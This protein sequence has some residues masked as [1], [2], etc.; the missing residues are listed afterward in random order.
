MTSKELEDLFEKN[1]ESDWVIDE[2]IGLSQN[3]LNRDRIALR[4]KYCGNRKEH[5]LGNIKYSLLKNYSHCRCQSCSR[6]QKRENSSI[7]LLMK[8]ESTLDGIVHLSWKLDRS[9]IHKNILYNAKTPL[10]LMCTECHT[11]KYHSWSNIKT[12]RINQD[13]IRCQECKLRNEWKIKIEQRT[14][15]EYV[16]D[17]HKTDFGYK[18]IHRKCGNYI[19]KDNP[20]LFRKNVICPFCFD[21][22]AALSKMRDQHQLRQFVEGRANLSFHF[23]NFNSNML[24][25]SCKLHPQKGKYTLDW[26]AFLRSNLKGKT[27][28]C[29]ECR[30]QRLRQISSYDYNELIKDFG[31]RIENICRE[32]KIDTNEKI[33]HFCTVQYHPPFYAS[34]YEVRSKNK[35]CPYC[36]NSISYHKDYQFIKNYVEM[37]EDRY[38]THSAKR[39]R[40]LSNKEEIESQPQFKKN[41]ASVRIRVNELTCTAHNEY[42]ISWGSFC[43]RNSGCR[44]CTQERNISY[45]HVYYQALLEYF[46][47]D[48]VS[49]FPIKINSNKTYRVDFKLYNAPCYVEIDSVI[50]VRG[51]RKDNYEAYQERDRLKDSILGDQ[52]E[53]IKMYDGN[54]QVLP[55]KDQIVII[56]SAFLKRASNNGLTITQKDIEEAK[57]SPTFFQNIHIGSLIKKLHLYHG[58]H[59]EFESKAYIN[60]LQLK[61]SSLCEFICV[62]HR[63]PFKRNIYSVFKKDFTCPICYRNLYEGLQSNYYLRQEKIDFIQTQITDRFNSRFTI[64]FWDQYQPAF[65]FR[66]IVFPV[67]DNIKQSELYMPLRDLLTL[68]VKLVHG[69]CDEGFYDHYRVTK[70]STKKGLKLKTKI[71]HIQFQ[72]S[73][74]IKDIEDNVRLQFTAQNKAAFNRY[75][76]NARNINKLMKSVEHK[77]NIN[78]LIK[79]NEDS[80]KN[81]LHQTRLEAVRKLGTYDRKIVPYFNNQDRFELHTARAKYVYNK[82]FLLIKDLRCSHF[83][84][85]PGTGFQQNCVMVYLLYNVNIKNVLTYFIEPK[86]W[87]SERYLKMIFWKFLQ[88]Y[89]M[90]NIFRP[91]QI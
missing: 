32:S 85:V 50:H 84:I 17:I 83:F 43:H 52:L 16:L 72:D 86:L 33:L 60:I 47:L 48:Y 12:C 49:E 10:P 68:P 67:K 71:R 56:E 46:G 45:A 54:N 61:D 27:F 65:F 41:T 91:I 55:M 76:Q 63:K 58:G 59:I 19:Y 14:N 37:D 3:I 18:L 31:L 8:V 39:F 88:I 22:K 34:Y 6:E 38:L 51:W 24:L 78:S 57:S 74:K 35:R 36:F 1:N 30:K 77:N 44:K 87:I 42:T 9:K 2:S 79:K 53:R 62:I 11:Y 40:L 66:T 23:F 73:V 25:V 70:S 75:Q 89:I 4:C 7:S 15:G 28:S 90:D 69:R 20:M 21:D 64:D 13:H 82:Q 29:T 80:F 81:Y 26:N 5:S